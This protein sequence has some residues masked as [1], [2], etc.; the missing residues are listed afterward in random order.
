LKKEGDDAWAFTGNDALACPLL[1]TSTDTL[2][3]IESG[4]VRMFT[5]VGLM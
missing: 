1:V 4:G 2:L 5:C 3:G